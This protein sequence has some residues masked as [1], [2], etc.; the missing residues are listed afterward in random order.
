M[1]SDIPSDI[2][3]I[4]DIPSCRYTDI[5]QIYL[6][7]YID[8]SDIP[9]DIQIHQI[10]LQIYRYIRYIQIYTDDIRYN[11]RYTDDIRYNFRYTDTSDIQMTSDIP[12]DIQMTSDTI[13][14]SD[15]Q[16]HQI[17]MQIHQI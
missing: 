4:S 9:S 16:I 7:I 14:I 5:H 15:I 1:T 3:M 12:S 10:Y 6:Q 17:Y 8:T 13:D 11:F 2:Q